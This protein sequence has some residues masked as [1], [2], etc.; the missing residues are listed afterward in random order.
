MKSA[1]NLKRRNNIILN[2]ILLFSIVSLPSYGA[3]LSNVP[4]TITQPDGTKIACFATGDEYYNWAH[5]KDIWK[6]KIY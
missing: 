3:Y 2:I 5:D 4:I 1:T 6:M